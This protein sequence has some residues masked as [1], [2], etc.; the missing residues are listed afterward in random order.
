MSRLSDAEVCPS[1]T[2]P[3]ARSVRVGRLL[4]GASGAA[5]T[6]ALLAPA[7]A[8]AQAPVAANP[9]AGAPAAPAPATTELQTVVV[10]GSRI[11]RK[12]YQSSS[13]LVTLS[14]QNLVQ[15]ADL[16]IQNTLNKLP[17]FAPD[18]NLMGAQSSDVQPTPTHS[19]GIAT[20][21][22]RGLGSNRNLVLIDGRRGAPVNGSLVVDLSTIP[23]AMIDH[24]ETITGGAS[25]VYGAD[26]VAGVVN[27]VM[28][29]NFHGVDFDTQFSRNQSGDGNQFQASAVFGTN[30]AD[31][32]GN[33]TFA[34]ERMQQDATKQNTHEFYRRGWNDPTVATNA[35]FGFAGGWNTG[36][37]NAPS[38]AAMS[39]VF[40][41]PTSQWYQPIFPG[42][43][44]LSTIY[45]SDA[46]AYTAFSGNNAGANAAYP[47]KLNG[48][49]VTPGY[50]VNSTTHQPVLGVKN[51][52]VNGFI[53]SPLDRWSFFTNGHYDFNDDI[54]AFFQANFARSHTATVLA[55]P[56]SAITGW[57]A[58]IPYD[59]ATNGVA[60]GHPVPGQLATLLNS[61]AQPNAP[62][63]LN[64]T[65]NPNG[66]IPP[67]STD[68]TN[69]VFQVTAGLN[70]RVPGN[71]DFTKDW[72]WE[73]YGS[74][75][76]SQQYTVAGG[77]WSL[78]RYQQMVQSAN[79]GAG[80]TFQGNLLQPNGQPSTSAGFGSPKVSC[81]SGFYNAIFNGGA[82]SSD[83]LNGITAP[84]Q[85][86][87]ITKQDEVEFSTQGTL[88]TL[89]A[90]DLKFSIGGDYRR[91][92]LIYNPDILQSNQSFAD[93]VIGVYPTA[94]VNASTDVK[95]GFGELSIPILANLPGIKSFTFNPGVRYSAYDASPANWT[96]KLLADWEINDWIRA[97]GGFNL[98]VRAPNVGE[99]YLGPTEVFGAGSAFADPCSLT[100]NAP[101]GAGGAAAVQ[102]KTAPVTNANGLAGAQNTYAICQALMGGAASQGA[103]TYY[104][105]P[106]SS[107]AGPFAWNYQQG[108]T[109][110]QPETARTVTAGL[111][112]NSPFRDTPWF[113]RARMTVDYYRIRIDD[114]IEFESID[115]IYR[116]CF[117]QPAATPSQLAAALATPAC[118]QIQRSPANGGASLN[119]T[120]SA[121]LATIDTAG[122]DIAAD[123]AVHLGD[124]WKSVPG[125]FALNVTATVLD[126]YDTKADPFSAWVKWKGT[127][128]PNLP[129][130]D[131]GA[132]D[133]KLN[134][135]FAYTLGPAMVNLN[136]RHLPSIKATASVF[137]NNVTMATNAYDIFDLNATYNLPHGMQLRGGIQNLADAMPAIT[138]ASVNNFNNLGQ[139]TAI[140]SSGYG[141]TNPGYYD[142]LGRRFYIGLRARF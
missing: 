67:R 87:D 103:L 39:Q 66:P 97:R 7:A 92:S 83:C 54:S 58:T 109:N 61:R 117:N 77:D 78:V 73:L 98:A 9:A 106:Q 65:P 107:S 37:G 38:T 23:T 115:Y 63:E 104:N 31:D 53:Q 42:T 12:D 80:Q 76:E 57:N 138:G 120:P 88:Y 47:Y 102:G 28:K 70:G 99:L 95:E 59:S 134:T 130:L 3:T 5:L 74:H 11:A 140:G 48:S 27:F 1:I 124:L 94:Y 52:F 135:S 101:F 112:I 50:Y 72:T 137:P 35:L 118:Q 132:Y 86:M 36:V 2:A 129:G 125:D 139:L 122:I 89:P 32:K 133:W 13:P 4:S 24:V 17:Q 71:H 119:F 75:S 56:I 91:D 110:L 41:G 128:G 93:Q 43:V 16:N 69:T 105:S 30:F 141:T 68:N 81:T 20:A 45:A 18:Q 62:W 113:S 60:S 34:I 126:H 100:S 55:A 26:A 90:G 108:S 123:W 64:W 15:Q 8:F 121:N 111:V 25:A 29:K 40:G 14:S 96:Y 142:A 49:S 21:S 114:A 136:W 131:S 84:L 10:T 85:S 116:N 82:L 6:L 127:F 33:L 51:D 79:W 44:Q 22:L 46:G 19:V